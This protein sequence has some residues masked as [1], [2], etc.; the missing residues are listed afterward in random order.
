MLEIIGSLAPEVTYNDLPPKPKGMHWSTYD[1]LAEHYDTYDTRWAIE[2]MRRLGL[3]LPNRRQAYRACA[4]IAA[5][6]A[7][8]VVQPPV[9]KGATHQIE[10]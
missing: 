6:L 5:P 4:F 8:G 2:I 7:A 1:C 9:P 3:R 10:M